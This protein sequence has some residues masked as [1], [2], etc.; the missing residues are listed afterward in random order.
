[1]GR[2]ARGRRR[3]RSKSKGTTTIGNY[4]EA[5]RKQVT[6]AARERNTKFKQTGVQTLG[7]KKTSFTKAEKAKIKAAGYTVDGYSKASAKSC[8]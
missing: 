6:D 2:G 4:R 8:T 1:M 5:Q 7:G 3:G